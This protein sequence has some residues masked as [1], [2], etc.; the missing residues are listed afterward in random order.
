MTRRREIMVGLVIVAGVAAAVLGTLWL[1]DASLG[2]GLRQSRPSF[3]KS[4]SSWKGT[5]SSSGE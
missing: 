3:R 1:K 2:R 4:A 5:R